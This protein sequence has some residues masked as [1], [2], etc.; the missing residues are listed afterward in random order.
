MFIRALSLERKR[1]ERSRKLFV[2]MV[3]ELRESLPNA[4]GANLLIRTAPAILSSFRATDIIGWHKTKAILGVI[5]T[6]LGATDKNSILTALRAKVTTALR[7][8][9]NSDEFERIN[10]SFHCFPDDWHANEPG[11]PIQ[12][13]YPDL[14]ERD[15]ARKATRAIKRAI[16]ILGS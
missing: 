4:Q 6:E 7:S 9:L 2:L 5:F 12:T 1:A 3:L 11:P 16:D 10:I 8:V 13:F 15:K 14:V